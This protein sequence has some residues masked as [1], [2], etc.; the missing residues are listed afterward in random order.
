[1]NKVFLSEKN[2]LTQ[3]RRLEK[4]LNIKNNEKSQKKCQRFLYVN[5]NNMI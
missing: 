4:I 2:I 5:M 1:M 3:S